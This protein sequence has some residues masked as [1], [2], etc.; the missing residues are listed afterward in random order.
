MIE[1]QEEEFICPECKG[2]EYEEDM[3][4]SKEPT[5]QNNKD[6]W[7]SVLQQVECL[8][9]KMIIPS[10]LGLRYDDITYEEAVAEWNRLYKKDSLKQ[11]F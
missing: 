9:C 5:S 10:H 6:P 3:F 1:D 11:K 4:M 2:T 8:G 7:A